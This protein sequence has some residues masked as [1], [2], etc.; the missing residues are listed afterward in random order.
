MSVVETLDRRR[1]TEEASLRAET[2]EVAGG[3]GE[4]RDS[5]WVTHAGGSSCVVV[6]NILER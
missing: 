5:P 1:N 2:K 6:G 3:M 4:G